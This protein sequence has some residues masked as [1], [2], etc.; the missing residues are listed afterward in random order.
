M[1]GRKWFEMISRFDQIGFVSAST[2]SIGPM[3][4]RTLRDFIFDLNS[5][6][7]VNHVIL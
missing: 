2:A 7:Y 4:N 6:R 5:K 3:H 1:R